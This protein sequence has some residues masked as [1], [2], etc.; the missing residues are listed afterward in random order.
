MRVF[1]ESDFTWTNSD[2]LVS[3]ASYLA[4]PAGRALSEFKIA[5]LKV[6]SYQARKADTLVYINEDGL[7]AQIFND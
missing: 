4:F 5:G 2:L 1:R 6:F 3:K 7:I